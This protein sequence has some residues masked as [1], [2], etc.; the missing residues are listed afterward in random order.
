M[1]VKQENQTEGWKKVTWLYVLLHRDTLFV[2]IGK[3]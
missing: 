3:C 1:L 2:Y